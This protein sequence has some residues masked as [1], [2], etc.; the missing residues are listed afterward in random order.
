MSAQ[1]ITFSTSRL[2]DFTSEKGLTSLTGCGADDWPF[3]VLKELVDNGID[4][5]E[6]AGVSPHLSIT[7]KDDNIV[8]EDNGPGIAADVV[9]RICDYRNQTSSHASYVGPERG[10]QGNALQT[11]F[12]LP[13]RRRWRSRRGRRN[14]S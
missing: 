7:I 10:Q 1:R 9:R 13:F 4:A 5:C 12:A 6:D 2:A 11:V 3:V 14:D 8:V